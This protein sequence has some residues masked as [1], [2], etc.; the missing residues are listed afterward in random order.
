VVDTTIE[1]Y[2]HVPFHV[3]VVKTIPQFC[4]T[5]KNVVYETTIEIANQNKPLHANEEIYPILVGNCRVLVVLVEKFPS[6]H[7]VCIEP[8][9][10]TQ[11]TFSHITRTI[12]TSSIPTRS[13]MVD[14][15]V[16]V[17]VWLT[18]GILSDMID[19]TTTVPLDRR[20]DLSKLPRY[21]TI[22]SLQHVVP[23]SRPYKRCLNYLE[24]KDFLLL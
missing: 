24:Y 11:N 23:Y 5:I 4:L 9:V 3:G 12:P 17:V 8:I 10:A 21:A 16:D 15:H 19:T 13:V 6:Q 22:T 14:P 2:I 1:E 18:T 20:G 7:I